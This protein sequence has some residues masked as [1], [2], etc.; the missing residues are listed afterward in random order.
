MTTYAGGRSPNSIHNENLYNQPSF[1]KKCYSQNVGITVRKYITKLNKGR[2]CK[3]DIEGTKEEGS[4]NNFS[5]FS[6]GILVM[7]LIDLNQSSTEMKDLS[8]IFIRNR[9]GQQ[10]L[11]KTFIKPIVSTI[12]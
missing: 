4:Q 3:K 10:M 5:S 11:D 2:V 6:K 12:Y 9:L 1:K 7:L 8:I